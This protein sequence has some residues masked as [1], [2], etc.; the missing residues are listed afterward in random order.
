MQKGFLFNMQIPAINLAAHPCGMYTDHFAF[1]EALIRNIASILITEKN[2]E[3]AAGIFETHDQASYLLEISLNKIPE[4]NL[5]GLTAAAGYLLQGHSLV[6]FKIISEFAD[7]SFYKDQCDILLAISLLAENKPVRATELLTEIAGLSSNAYL[8]LQAGCIFNTMQ[9]WN[10]A[11]LAFSKAKKLDKELAESNFG[12]G[13]AVL[14]I[15]DFKAAEIIFKQTLNEHAEFNAARYSLAETLYCLEEYG[16][17]A[18]LFFEVHKQRP[19][20]LK[21][22]LWLR[23]IGLFSSVA[24]LQTVTAAIERLLKGQINIV[25][26]LPFSGSNELAA[27]LV[28]SGF[29]CIPFQKRNGDKHIENTEQSLISAIEEIEMHTSTFLMLSLQDLRHLPESYFYRIVILK[30]DIDEAAVEH[31]K[32]KG[33]N[34][35]SFPMGL[36][37]VFRLQAWRTEC[38]VRR[39][40]QMSV[41]EVAYE[42]LKGS[43]ESAVARA[44]DFF[45]DAEEAI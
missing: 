15:G 11:T 2:S 36:S 35:K 26:S 22:L 32:T 34:G 10:D 27:A 12:Y 37:N 9:R 16:E 40:P 29:T 19:D 14:C 20:D 38:L 45:N 17:S 13:I 33:K 41:L 44:T 18:L 28:N 31:Q 4:K 1:R 30:R 24:Q 5:S 7:K 8:L 21:T 25:C 42:D 3:L 6:A 43:A 23:K 39:S